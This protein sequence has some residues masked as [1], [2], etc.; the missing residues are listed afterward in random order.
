LNHIVLHAEALAAMA[1]GMLLI[2]PAGSTGGQ[3]RA[4]DE[5]W[6]ESGKLSLDFKNKVS[7]MHGEALKIVEVAKQGNYKQ[8][9]KQMA[10]FANNGCRSCHSDYRGE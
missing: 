5:I 9:K 4:M 8:I 3:S 6:D 10:V 7:V 2:F 1:E